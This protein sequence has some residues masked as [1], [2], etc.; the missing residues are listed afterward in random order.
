MVQT[1]AV[2]KRRSSFAL[3]RRSSRWPRAVGGAGTGAIGVTGGDIGIG[4]I[5]FPTIGN[6]VNEL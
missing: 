5:A 6:P 3:R 4:G 2:M 1:I